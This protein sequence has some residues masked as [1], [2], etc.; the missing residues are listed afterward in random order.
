[1]H[2]SAT[3][4]SSALTISQSA[5]GMDSKEKPSALPIWTRLRRFLNLT[6]NRR[7]PFAQKRLSVFSQREEKE[8]RLKSPRT[9][10]HPFPSTPIVLPFSQALG[11]EARSD[12]VITAFYCFVEKLLAFDCMPFAFLLDIYCQCVQSLPPPTTPPL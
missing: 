3:A 5:V 10:K 11:G 12:K 1:M 6:G 2:N 7:D 9:L 8:T 4:P